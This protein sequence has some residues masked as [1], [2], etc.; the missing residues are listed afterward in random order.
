M[1]EKK[2]IGQRVVKEHGLI[3]NI[4]PYLNTIDS[5]N[6]ANICTRTY[7]VTVPYNLQSHQMQQQSYN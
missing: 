6:I 1:L 5:V 2:S 3:S 4:L 7:F